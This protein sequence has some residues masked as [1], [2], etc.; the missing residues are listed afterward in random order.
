MLR[1]QVKSQVRTSNDAWKGAE[2]TDYL[3]WK[4]PKDQIAARKQAV[5]QRQLIDRLSPSRTQYKSPDQKLLRATP[6]HTRNPALDLPNVQDSAT[7]RLT[8]RRNTQVP[9]EKLQ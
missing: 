8:S 9:V 4:T 6:E 1:E 5:K 7:A 3:N 2:I